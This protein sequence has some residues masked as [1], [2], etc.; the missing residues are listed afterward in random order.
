MKIY[1]VVGMNEN[2][3]TVIRHIEAATRDAAIE[4]YMAQVALV[5]GPEAS[6]AVGAVILCNAKS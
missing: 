2:G 6:I 1:R 4:A 3:E 5:Y